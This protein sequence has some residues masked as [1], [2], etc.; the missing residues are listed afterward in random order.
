MVSN[1]LDMEQQELIDLLKTFQKRYAGD[2]EYAA[3]RAE[4]PKSWPFS[5]RGRR[6]AGPRNESGAFPLQYTSRRPVIACTCPSHSKLNASHP[7]RT[8]RRIFSCVS[9][10]RAYRC[11]IAICRSP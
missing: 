1:V 4:L 7:R 9:S 3:L 2:A 5:R 10:S 11:T 8:A 6:T